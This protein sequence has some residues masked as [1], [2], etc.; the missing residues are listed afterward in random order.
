[1]FGNFCLESFVVSPALL[2]H[3]FS[4]SFCEAIFFFKDLHDDA[5]SRNIST[6]SKVLFS[7]FMLDADELWASTRSQ[8]GEYIHTDKYPSSFVCKHVQQSEQSEKL[9]GL[10]FYQPLQMYS[11]WFYCNVWFD[12]AGAIKGAV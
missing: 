1:M 5:T 9:L 12:A 3:K 7:L 8:T 10:F 6:S 4:K 2:L 11:L